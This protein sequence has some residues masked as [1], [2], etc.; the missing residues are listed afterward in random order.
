MKDFHDDFLAHYGTP[1][2]S[3]RYPWGS[4][5]N[6]ERSKH[7]RQREKE[8]MANGETIKD[9]AEANG[10]TVREYKALRAAMKNDQWNRD[11]QTAMALREKGMSM[12][13]ISERMGVPISTVQSYL[14]PSRQQR[15]KQ[16][17]STSDALKR[18]VEEKGFI[19]VS[20]GVEHQLGV[21]RNKMDDTVNILKAEG[22]TVQT[23]KVPQLGTNKLTTMKILAP[24]GT[25]A[26]EVWENRFKV[27]TIDET[28]EDGGITFEKRPI[29]NISSKR[30][31]IKYAEDGGTDMDGVIELRRGV[32]DLDLGQSRYA[33]VRI[34]VD[35]THYLKGMAIYADDLPDGIDIRFNTNKHKDVSKMDVMKKQEPDPDNPFKASLKI[36][37]E[38]RRGYLNVVREEGDWTEWSSTLASQFLSKQEVSLAK[39]QLGIALKEKQDEFDDIMNLTNPLVRKTFLESFADDCDSAA[40]HLKAAAMPRQSTNVILPLPS[41]K[42]NEIYAPNYQNGEE[43]VLVR[44]P[45]GGIFEIPRLIVNNN[46]KD[47]KRLFPNA[48]DAV[49]IHPEAAAQLSGAD[50]DGDTV[51]VIPTKGFKIKT[52]PPFEGLKDFDPKEAFPSQPGMKSIGKK[53]GRQEHL[54]MGKVSNLIT[55]MTLAGASE[56][57]LTRA[58]RHSM[59]VI[60]AAKHKLNYKLSEE[61]NGI[62]ELKAKY[63]KGGASTLISAA[64]SP[65]RVPYRADY[66]KID[67]KTG[68]KIWI[69]KYDKYK[70]L[71]KQTGNWE[72]HTRTINST[73]MYETEDAFTLS[74]GTKM[75]NTY[76]SYANSLK[77]LGNQAR[78]AYAGIETPKENKSVKEK[79]A[80]EISSL[81]EKL[82]IAEANAPKER[83][84][85]TIGN[86]LLRSMVD[87]NPELKDNKD[88]Y[89]KAKNKCLQRGRELAGAH[90]TRVVFS[91]AEVEAVNSGAISSEKLKKLLRN[92]DQDKLKESFTPRVKTTMTPARIARAKQLLSKGYTAAQVA[93]ALGVSVKTLNNNL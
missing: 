61:V 15:F 29:K 70:K 48:K 73:K 62:A 55:D 6:P 33:Q 8:A 37:P 40:V 91:E 53:G 32:K 59:V 39:R 77:S 78:K 92:A 84:A 26:K 25:T 36:G 23:V 57:E 41:L 75:E 83:R 81:N 42:K 24:P 27:R 67:P 93:E 2:H 90:K 28:S 19:D 21:T 34:A 80:S 50:F 13:A 87:A 86:Y 52:S 43:V 88:E 74:S 44:Y 89:K 71:N 11:S 22:Y 85:Q 10:I 46:N 82:R 72:E 35:G 14:D 20:A 66:Y 16:I 76:A 3:G 5:K 68:K 4:G 9:R 12:I 63:Q 49:G 30:I 58:V 60:D 38:G 64:K 31:A 56:E 7:W 17:Q 54:E 1:R 18:A 45:H 51:L 69:P 79:Y 65:E 47:G